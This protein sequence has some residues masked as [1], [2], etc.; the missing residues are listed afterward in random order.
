MR[1]RQRHWKHSKFFKA[2]LGVS[3]ATLL[4]LGV[5]FW[6]L[7]FWESR[8]ITSR[9]AAPQGI[10]AL[11]NHFPVPHY[12]GPKLPPR[13]TFETHRPAS[14]VPLKDL[15]KFT[16]AAFVTSEDAGFWKHNG[17][18]PDGMREAME[19][20][21]RARR[22]VR[23]ASTITQQVAKNLFLSRE[24]TLIRKFKELLIARELE[25]ALPK[26]RILELY[27]NCIEFGEGTYG[28]GP[29]S[30]L[31]FKKRAEQLNPKEAAFLAMLLPN[32]VRNSQSFRNHRLTPFAER[33]VLRVL[34]RLGKAG[35]LSSEEVQSAF[36]TPLAF[37]TRAVQSPQIPSERQTDDDDEVT[38]S[39][40]PEADTP[41]ADTQEER[42][43][44]Q[45][46]DRPPP[47][48]PATE[49]E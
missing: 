29:A 28:I 38:E 39:G 9:A 27:L 32:P 12:V 21:I 22:Y 14:W 19:T 45:E 11:K 15:A 2:S 40:D 5:I 10:S 49:E 37:E 25:E 6:S 26:R 3:L 24:K 17:F 47:T 18:D 46:F 4:G 35:Y 13:F 48:E 41:E 20:N 30:H 23:G 42:R 1:R 34:R 31:Y 33:G 7:D 44:I 16:Q 43:S 8:L 36:R